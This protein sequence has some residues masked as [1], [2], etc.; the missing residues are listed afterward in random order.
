MW[1]DGKDF[2]VNPRFAASQSCHR[3]LSFEF[4]II[5]SVSLPPG[6]TGLKGFAYEVDTNGG[7]VGLRVGIV[8]ESKQ[9]ARL[10]YTGITDEKQLEEVVVS[11]RVC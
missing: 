3:A 7:N 9:Q 2:G 11:D 8:G 1:L 5:G 4:S 10:A 6:E